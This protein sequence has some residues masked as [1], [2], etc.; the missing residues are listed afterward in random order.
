MIRVE[1][2]VEIEQAVSQFA[3]AMTTLGWLKVKIQTRIKNRRKNV[4]ASYLE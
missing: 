2:A 3:D 4:V 1:V